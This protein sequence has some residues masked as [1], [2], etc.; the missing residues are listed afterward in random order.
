MRPHPKNKFLAP[1]EERILRSALL[2]KLAFSLICLVALTLVVAVRTSYSW[3]PGMIVG[4]WS[5]VL[6]VGPVCLVFAIRHAR[7]LRQA[8]RRHRVLYS[9]GHIQF[10]PR[11]KQSV[12]FDAL[13]LFCWPFLPL[14]IRVSDSQS[15]VVLYA[16]F[17]CL[18]LAIPL[19]LLSFFYSIS[20][21]TNER[22]PETCFIIS[23]ALKVC[24]I[25]SYITLFVLQGCDVHNF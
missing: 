21:P 7:Q 25:T 6:I 1:E 8:M 18:I 17:L 10:S 5:A 9:N 3:S 15:A 23:Y 20:I 22:H 16:F 24:S 2:G 14:F 12:A 4:A 11:M 19:F 13:F